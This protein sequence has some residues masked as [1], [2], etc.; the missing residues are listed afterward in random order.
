MSGAIFLL[1]LC[2]TAAVPV[3]I[4]VGVLQFAVP[5][6]RGVAPYVGL[7]YPAAYCGGF[8]GVVAVLRL[9]A[10]A[11]MSALWWQEILSLALF[12]CLLGGAAVGGFL[13]Y[14]LA[15][16]IAKYFPRYRA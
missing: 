13:G 10:L 5:K 7:V 2:A 1:Y 9:G 4:V 3:C 12:A 6:S 8:L 11:R 14:K 16:R 15:G